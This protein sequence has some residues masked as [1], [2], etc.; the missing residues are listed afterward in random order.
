MFSSFYV[1]MG[2][3][4]NGGHLYETEWFRYEAIEEA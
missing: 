2:L 3:P 4:V 1:Q